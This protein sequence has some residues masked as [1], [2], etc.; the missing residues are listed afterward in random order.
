MIELVDIGLLSS[1]TSFFAE[2]LPSH[3]VTITSP[4]SNSH[5]YEYVNVVVEIDADNSY[6]YVKLFNG[7]TEI[8]QDFTEPYEFNWASHN[9]PHGSVQQLKAVGLGVNEK[10]YSSAVVGYVIDSVVGIPNA[11]VLQPIVQF[12]DSSVSL[13]WSQYT[14]DDFKMYTVEIASD[15]LN[16]QFVQS[17]DMVNIF[18]TTFTI[19][20]LRELS[21]YSFRIK[22]TDVFNLF[23]VS[24]IQVATTLNAVPPEIGFVNTYRDTSIIHIEWYQPDIIDFSESRVYRSLDS[25]RSGDDLHVGTFYNITDTVFEESMLFDTIDYFYFIEIQDADGLYSM[26]ALNA[27]YFSLNY[28]LAFDGTQCATIPYFSELN[29]GEHFTLEAWIFQNSSFDANRIIDRSTQYVSP[30]YQYALFADSR[31]GTTLCSDDAAIGTIHTAG[32]RPDYLSWHHVAVTYNDG[33]LKFYIDGEVVTSLSLSSRTLCENLMPLTIGRKTLSEESYFDGSIDE[34]RVWN[35]VR[36]PEEILSNYAKSL[37]GNENGL[38]LYL[39]FNEGSGQVVHSPVGNNGFLGESDQVDALDP[40]W[41]ISV[42][43]FK[44]Y[45]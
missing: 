30:Y 28:A 13:V 41:E 1:T 11:G 42:L 43:N 14:E 24:N 45:K 35:V 8:G 26:T 44:Y 20:G 17:Y 9:Y 38:V 7:A 37:V 10:E 5:V 23:S 25:I 2:F 3:I 33:Q 19:Y 40:T 27:F 21:S 12:T 34:V 36:S 4:V 18:D 6:T 15:T 31:L 22:M 29:L 32:S 16:P 39:D